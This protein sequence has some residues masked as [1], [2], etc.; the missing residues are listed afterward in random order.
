MGYKGAVPELETS[1]RLSST[2]CPLS[3]PAVIGCKTFDHVPALLPS[4]SLKGLSEWTIWGKQGSLAHTRW[5]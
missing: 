4:A 2:V 1:A 5:T 3:K